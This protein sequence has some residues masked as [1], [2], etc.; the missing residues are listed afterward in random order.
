MEC[1]Y[2]RKGEASVLDPW[3]APWKISPL[4]RDTTNRFRMASLS[5]HQSA[6][7]THYSPITTKFTILKNVT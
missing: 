2:I 7:T 5:S 1:D 6:V 4:H 3:D